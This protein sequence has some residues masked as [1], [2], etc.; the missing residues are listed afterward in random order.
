MTKATKLTHNHRDVFHRH[1]VFNKI[2]YV[3]SATLRVFVK[4]RVTMEKS[5]AECEGF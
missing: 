5:P 1:T 3:A 2:K 4:H